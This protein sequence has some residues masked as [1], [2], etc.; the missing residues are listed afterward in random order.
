MIDV[1]IPVYSAYDDV[2]RCVASA[3]RYAGADCRIVLIDDASPDVRIKSLFLEL[4]REGDSRMLFLANAINTGFVGTVNRGMSLSRN[5]IVLLNSDTIAT[6]RWLEKIQR[7]ANSSPQIGT[8]TPFSNN[9]EICSFPVFCQNN[10]LDGVDIER[11]NQA[12]EKAAVPA[13]PDI[14]TAVGFCMFIRRG[15]LDAIGLFDAESFGRGYGEENDFCMRAMKAGYRNVLCDD[16]FVAH[17]GSQSFTDQTQ[18][19]KERN[20]QVLFAKHPEYLGLVQRFIAADPIAPIRE[21]VQA[22]L[23]MRSQRPAWATAISRLFSGRDSR[24]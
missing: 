5:D 14:P 18:A 17:V 23:A 2:V 4:E 6:S 22:R 16:T 9:A 12:M 13:Y 11:I 7:C 8:I 3:R 10:P 20:S 24:G 19:L 21:R 15:L 1:I